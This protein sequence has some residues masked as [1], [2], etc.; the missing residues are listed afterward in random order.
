MGKKIAFWALS[1]T[2]AVAIGVI[3]AANVQWMKADPIA[4]S[5][6]GWIVMMLIGVIFSGGIHF[7]TSRDA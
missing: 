5:S 3:T 6:W 7:A 4:W 1:L 2:L